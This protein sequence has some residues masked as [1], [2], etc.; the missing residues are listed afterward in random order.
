MNVYVVEDDLSCSVKLEAMLES[1]GDYQ[2]SGISNSYSKAVNE[3]KRCNPDIVIADIRLDGAS[4]GIDL[5]QELV[6]RAISFI[7]VTAFSDETAYKATKKYA[8]SKF[9]V[10]PYD[11][12]TLKGL[13]DDINQDI[14]KL[15]KNKTIKSDSIFIKKNNVFEKIFL[16][17]L[18][19]MYSEGNYITFFANN[20]KFVIKY[21]LSKLLQLKRFQTFVRVH[22]SYAV[23]MDKIDAINFSEKQL[24][25]AGAKIPFGRTYAKNVRGLMTLR[26]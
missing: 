7:F 3:I 14:V 19:Y 9:I 13:L 25:I 18:D 4:S 23:H 11:V 12:L 20:K 16:N 26:L 24:T 10:K 21:S 1:I 17:D 2:L 15:S 6:D 8:G 22:R 5:A